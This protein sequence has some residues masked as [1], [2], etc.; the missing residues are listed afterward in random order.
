[1]KNNT[2]FSDE[3][4]LGIV[5]KLQTEYSD[6]PLTEKQV[7]NIAAIVDNFKYECDE[8]RLLALEYTATIKNQILFHI[9]KVVRPE[10]RV[11]YRHKQYVTIEGIAKRVIMTLYPEKKFNL[12]EIDDRQIEV[13]VDMILRD[14]QVELLERKSVK[15]KV[16]KKKN[17]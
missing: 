6:D 2:L 7:L 3:E 9:N 17:I 16:L 11:N 12:Y 1:M 15:N 13:I 4:I 5:D 14:L 10:Q 8:D